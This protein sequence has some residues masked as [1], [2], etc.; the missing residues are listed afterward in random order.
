M[1]TGPIDSGNRDEPLTTPLGLPFLDI[2][3]GVYGESIEVEPGGLR[4]GP[5]WYFPSEMVGMKT[6]GYHFPL[7]RLQRDIDADCENY[8]LR[9]RP[10]PELLVLADWV[11]ENAAAWAFARVGSYDIA[12]YPDVVETALEVARDLRGERKYHEHHWRESVHPVKAVWFVQKMAETLGWREP[13]EASGQPGKWLSDEY[14]S[15]W[16]A[17]EMWGEFGRGRDL[18]VDACADC[19]HTIVGAAH[20][21]WSGGGSPE[22]WANLLRMFPHHRF[23]LGWPHDPDHNQPIANEFTSSRCPCC[24]E[25]RDGERYKVLGR[26]VPSEETSAEVGSES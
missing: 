18:F 11:E 24:G 13:D 9:Y 4:F 10:E 15:V 22:R 17:A 19:I 20:D 2:S 23:E 7:S 16:N 25:Y 8:R 3:Q 6:N 26:F 5:V 1:V 12:G 14:F 21:D